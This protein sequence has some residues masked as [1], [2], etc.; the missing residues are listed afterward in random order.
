MPSPAPTAPRTGRFE[1]AD[2]GTILLD[3]ISEIDLPLQAKLLRVL[4]EK[5]FERVGSSS[6]ISVDV[7]MLATSNR[8]LTA[9]IADGQFREDL[10]YRLAVVPLQVPPLRQRRDD[11]PEL[12]AHFLHRSCATAAARP[13]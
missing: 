6:T 7:R 11:I 4:Q 9:E 8:D 5:S 10:Y 3:E 1:L 2:G 12:V 13:V